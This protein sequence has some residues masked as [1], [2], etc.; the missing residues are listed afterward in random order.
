[1]DL[2]ELIKSRRSIRQFKQKEIAQDILINCVD[3]AR[4][5]PS[6]ANLQ[7]LE[8]I[9][10]TDNEQVN[11]LFSL[12]RWAAYINPKG[13]PKPGQHPTAYLIIL[14]N[15]DYGKKWKFHDLGAAVEN[16]ML[17]ALSYGIGTCWLASV[18]RDPIRSY[19]KIPKKY[20]IDSVVAL[21]Y[22]A[23][24]PLLETS[25][26][27]VRY[28]QDGEDRLHVPKR[29]IDSILRINSFKKNKRNDK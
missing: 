13:N 15:K 18:D 29:S 4:T 3:A 16:F 28:W 26:E 24:E 23:E 17:A 1:M 14:L 7:P 25:D 11:Y 9:L 5:A 2:V 27:T 12:V 6:A 21:G 8:Y 10:V 22:P 20:L 19:Y